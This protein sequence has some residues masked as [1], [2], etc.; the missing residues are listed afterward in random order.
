VKETPKVS[1]WAEKLDVLGIR[2]LTAVTFLV[3]DDFQTQMHTK[4]LV[5]REPTP[6]STTEACSHCSDLKNMP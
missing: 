5:N 6:P 3:N 2:S 1:E 4:A